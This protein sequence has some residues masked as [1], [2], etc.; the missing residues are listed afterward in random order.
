MSAGSALQR[1]IQ[2]R[3]P[4]SSQQEEAILAIARTAD[5]LRRRISRLIE[6]YGVTEQQYNVL[7]ILRGAGCDGLPTLD[8]A[9]RMIEQTPGI[10]RMIDRLETKGLVSRER[11]CQDR[12]QV[13][14]QISQ[15]GLDLLAKLDEPLRQWGLTA[16]GSLREQ[17]MDALILTLARIRAVQD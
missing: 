6:P 4:F 5:V 17:E 2:Q 15:T 10:T 16:L 7:R 1:E 11:G 14:C 8:I 9:E 3:V 13:L 12:R